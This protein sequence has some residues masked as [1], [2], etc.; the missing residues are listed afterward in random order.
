MARASERRRPLGHPHTRRFVSPRRFVFVPGIPS[1]VFS[2]LRALSRGDSPTIDALA[3]AAPPIRAIVDELAAMAPA[4]FVVS[5]NDHFFVLRFGAAEV[6]SGPDGDDEL[7]AYAYDSLGERLCEGCKRAYVLRFDAESLEGDENGTAAAVAA[8][9][10]D[11][12]VAALRHL[13]DDVAAPSPGTPR[14]TEPDP[15]TLMRR[16]Q[17]EFHRVEGAGEGGTKT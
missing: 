3:D 17:I 9:L 14:A 5:W 16:L 12:S 2:R 15:E 13:A 4:T 7:A 1:S 6:E 8:Y 11:V 10:G